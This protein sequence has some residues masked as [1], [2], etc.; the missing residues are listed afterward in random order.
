MIAHEMAGQTRAAEEEY[1]RALTLP[2]INRTLIEGTALAQ[3]MGARDRASLQRLLPRAIEAGPDQAAINGAALK[4]LDDP[5]AA[6]RELHR[7]I[8]EPGIQREM[9]TLAALGLWAAYF[10]DDTLALDALRRTQRSGVTI[11]S[12]GISLWRPVMKGVRRLAGFKDLLREQGLVDY[13][14][15]SGNWGEFCKPVGA[16]DFEC[17]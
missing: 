7:L 6:L 14:R 17:R 1:Q 10:G 9:Y 11:E 15:K 8:D 5:P 16:D 12:W 4:Y 3:A 2:S 13:W